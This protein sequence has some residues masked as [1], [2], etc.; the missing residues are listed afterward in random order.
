MITKSPLSLDELAALAVLLNRYGS[1]LLYEATDGALID[2]DPHEKDLKQIK[3]DKIGQAM[4]VINNDLS[5]KLGTFK[6]CV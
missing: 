5:G 2:E 6:R 1:E 4:E 3:I